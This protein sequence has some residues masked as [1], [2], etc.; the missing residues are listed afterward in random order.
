[1]KPI[2]LQQIRRATGGTP[3]TVLPDAAPLIEAVSTD[4]RQ[5]QPGALYVAL[6]GERYDGH[7]FLPDV[8]RAGAVAAVVERVP[9][10]PPPDLHLLRVPDT[11]AALGKVAQLVRRQMTAKVIAV[12]G[13][14]GKTS[15]K[16]LIDAALRLKLRGTVSPK[17]FNNNVGVPL[18]IFPA[19]PH[20]DYLV[21]EMGTNHHGEIL[22]LTQMAL[23]DIAVITNCGAEHLE[24]LDDLMG[25]RRENATVAAGLGGRGL[26]VVNGDDP[27]LLDAVA[28]FPARKI[29]FGFNET[30]DLFA[31]DVS[32]DEG[33]CRFKLNGRREVFVPLTGRHTASNALAAI[34]VARRLMVSEEV[35]FEGLSQARGPDMRLEFQPAGD[36]TILND[37]YNANP[38]SMRAALDTLAGLNVGARRLAVL[39]DMLELGRSSERYHKELGEHAATAGKLDVLACVGPQSG[40][41]ADAAV[42]AGLPPTAVLRFPNAKAAAESL[43][44]VVRPGDLVLVK[45]SRG[46]KLEYVADAIRRSRGPVTEKAPT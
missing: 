42:A 16:L 32:W 40:A 25:V 14:N 38:N 8:A 35:I 12:A 21:L 44:R 1:M 24:G 4:S 27:Y 30:N 31:T 17:S 23:P 33:G 13:S 41:M 11:Y 46:V 10:E 19:D 43:S 28:S 6:R 5:V 18:T 36:V 37:A 22:P 34:A 9:Q 45:A 2:T 3:L 20:Q 15:T 39:G 7:D 26:L 29:T